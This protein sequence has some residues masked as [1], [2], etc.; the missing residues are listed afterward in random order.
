MDCVFG[1]AMNLPKLLPALG[2]A[3]I[4]LTGCERQKAPPLAAPG[5]P[6]VVV[7]TV[8]RRDVPIVREWI[9][10][11]DG[12]ANLDVRAR[13]QGYV[14]Q[15]AFKE[16]TMVKTGDLLLRIDPR[17]LEA[18]LAQAKAELAQAVASQKKADLDEQRQTRLFSKDQQPAGLRQRRTNQPG[19]E[20]RG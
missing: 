9:G 5:P 6:Q 18:A 16:G 10:S 14:Q 19:G 2:V 15:V 12:S 3:A 1:V 17:P 7:L 4:A 20:G 11:L 13:V 8:E